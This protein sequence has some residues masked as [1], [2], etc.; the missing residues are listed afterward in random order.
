MLYLAWLLS[1]LSNVPSTKYWSLYSCLVNSNTTRPTKPGGQEDGMAGVL[2]PMLCHNPHESTSWR[3]LNYLSGVLT[4][5]WVIFYSSSL[6]RRSSCRTSTDCILLCSVR[7]HFFL[8][9]PFIY[10]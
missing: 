3:L 5:W 2:E 9:I 4:S 10:A 1:F 6:L 7:L 8:L